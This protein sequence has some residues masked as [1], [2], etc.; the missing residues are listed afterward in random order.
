M[1]KRVEPRH[2]GPKALG[3][4]VPHGTRTLVIVRPRALEWDLLPARW[5]GDSTHAPEFCAFGRDEAAAAARRLVRILESA[6]ERGVNPL[7][8]CSDAARTSFQIWLRT[9]EFIWIACRRTPGRSYQPALFDA[10]EEATCAAE[11]IAAV[12]WPGAGV[13]QEYYFN[14]QNFS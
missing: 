6:V 11:A 7:Q 14:T 2:A 9:E 13:T 8:T 3:I 1:L 12:V 10:L 4:L 5:D